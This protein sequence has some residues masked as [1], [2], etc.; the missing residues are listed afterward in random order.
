MENIYNTQ[1]VKEALANLP[2]EYKVRCMP[3]LD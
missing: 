1:K 3:D 2:E